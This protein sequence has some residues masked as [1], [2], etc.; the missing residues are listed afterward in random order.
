[1]FSLLKDLHLRQTIFQ[2]K[3]KLS[4]IHILVQRI[5]FLQSE[6]RLTYSFQ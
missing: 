3:V 4:Y 1:M 2:P 5:F 6:I